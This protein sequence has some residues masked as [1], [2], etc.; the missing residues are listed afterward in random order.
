MAI[1]IRPPV[2]FLAHCI[3]QAN[4]GN[5]EPQNAYVY[6]R[7]AYDQMLRQFNQHIRNLDEEAKLQKFGKKFP[8]VGT[9]G[10]VDHPFHTEE[11]YAQDQMSVEGLNRLRAS[12]WAARNIKTPEELKIDEAP[13]IS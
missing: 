7:A 10:H 11:S 13:A 12:M 4:L 5:F 3:Q 2:K 6:Q 1:P 8:N 9:I